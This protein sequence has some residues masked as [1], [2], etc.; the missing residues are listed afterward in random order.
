MIF[1][2]QIVYFVTRVG[3]GVFDEYGYE[4]MTEAEVPVEGCYHQPMRAEEA[5]QILGTV[6]TQLWKTIAP[7]EAAAVAAKST[8]TLKEGGRTFHIVGG[9]QPMRD[10]TNPHHV[11]ILSEIQS[12]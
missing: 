7:P 2:S 11:T 9:A 6:A 8:G 5:T 12:V 10:F 4:T 3:T 1:G